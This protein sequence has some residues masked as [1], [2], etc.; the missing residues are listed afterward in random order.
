MAADYQKKRDMLAEALS[1][2]GFE[3]SIP[4]GSYYMLAKI[5]DDFRDDKEAAQSLLETTR[6]ASVPGSAFFVSEVGKRMLRF[7]YAKDFE[8]LEE[9][10]KRLR[11]FKPAAV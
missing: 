6:V 4:Q 1:E 5:P 3:P 11:A 2:A 10:C 7:C 8:S 9:A